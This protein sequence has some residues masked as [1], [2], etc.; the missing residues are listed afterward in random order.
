MY[1]NCQKCC[2]QQQLEEEC[3]AHFSV[4]LSPLDC[5]NQ[6]LHP[7]VLVLGKKKKIQLPYWE[8]VLTF[9]EFTCGLRTNFL[10]AQGRNWSLD[11]ELS[12][13]F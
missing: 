10:L 9:L 13:Q 11:M 12:F 5:S 6:Q 1:L 4:T 8:N 3:V 7:S 2:E